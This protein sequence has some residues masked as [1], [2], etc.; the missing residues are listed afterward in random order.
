[1]GALDWIKF[2]L[3]IKKWLFLAHPDPIIQEMPGLGKCVVP[4]LGAGKRE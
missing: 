3:K 2:H 1:M 4:V